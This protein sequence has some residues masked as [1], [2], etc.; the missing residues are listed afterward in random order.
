MRHVS[1]GLLEKAKEKSDD[2]GEGAYSATGDPD[3]PDFKEGEIVSGLF[4][5]QTI[6]GR[7][8]S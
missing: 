5:W 3:N 8:M 4:G 7:F 1:G 6:N 2:L